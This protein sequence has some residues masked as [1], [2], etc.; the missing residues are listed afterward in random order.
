MY[1]ETQIKTHHCQ[2]KLE[3][4]NIQNFKTKETVSLKPKGVPFLDEFQT[5]LMGENKSFCFYFK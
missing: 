2:C 1:R 4:R 3:M 5:S